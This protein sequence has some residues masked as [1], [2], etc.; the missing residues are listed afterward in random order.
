MANPVGLDHIRRLA[1]RAEGLRRS[2]EHAST[3]LWKRVWNTIQ[4]YEAQ[5]ADAQTTALARA[6]RLQYLGILSPSEAE[7]ALVE[8]RWLR[9]GQLARRFPEQEPRL[10]E[11]LGARWQAALDSEATK[12]GLVTPE[13]DSSTAGTSTPTSTGATA[14][15]LAAALYQDAADAVQAAMTIAR[16]VDDLP[17]EA[18]R[19]HAPTVAARALQAMQGVP[20]YLKAQLNR[21]ATLSVL[22]SYYQPPPEDK[23]KGKE[24]RPTGRRSSSSR[25]RS[26]K[27]RRKT[28][29]KSPARSK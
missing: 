10:R 25:S 1:R 24:K 27:S 21:L 11:Q 4:A 7:Q 29:S 6:E 20:V 15:H 8:G 14:N 17:E 16:A 12:R 18:G 2:S 26:T 5:L 22:E 23:S 28:P 9:V 19:Y 3:W 13:A